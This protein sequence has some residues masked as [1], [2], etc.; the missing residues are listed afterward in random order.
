MKDELLLGIETSCDETA[1]ALLRPPR[2]ILSSVVASQ[3]PI[4]RRF[5]G[6]VPELA[7]RQ[8]LLCIDTVVRD[9]LDQAGRRLEDLTGVAVTYGPG[10]VGSLLVGIQVAKAIAYTHRLPLAAVNHLEGHVRSLYLENAEVPLPALFLV[11]SGGHTALYLSRRDDG[12]YDT[13]ARTR[14]DAAGEAYDKV[15]KF[16]GLGY[17]GG[18]IVDR[19]ARHGD[20]R[21][22][23]FG[24]PRMTDGSLDFS[25]SGFKTAV[26]RHV[27]AA[28]IEP[29]GFLEAGG[30]EPAPSDCPKPVL[31][32]LASFQ[33]AVVRALAERTVQAARGT[34][35]ACVGLA[36]GVACNSRLREVMAE[37]GRRLGVPVLLTRPALTTDNAAM[38]ARAGW[39]HLRRGRAADLSLNA[40]PSAVL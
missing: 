17:P 27:A 8:H 31:D 34:R 23:A 14:D 38:I 39:E 36:G 3:I 40:D 25:F 10:L 26:L 11:V 28:G 32:L 35:A 15:A 22:F 24:R 20:P 30:R 5:G 29:L 9:A 37:E 6:V 12:R 19:L 2:E 7:S 16:L 21:A 33:E 1:A 18:P 13:L 4:H